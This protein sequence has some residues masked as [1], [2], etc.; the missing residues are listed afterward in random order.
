[1]TKTTAQLQKGDQAPAFDLP[2]S[3][4]NNISLK[5]LKGKYAVIYF[6]PKDNTPGCTIEACGFRDGNKEIEK[7]NAVIVGVSP[8]SVASH[9]RFIEKFNLPFVLVSDEDKQMCQDYGVW[10]KKNKFGRKYMGVDRK[11]FIVGKNGKILKIFEKVKPAE[12]TAEVID[13][14]KSLS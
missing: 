6:Y 11:T 5:P 13:F 10:I 9:N 8:D 1:M 7:L 12:H 4:G 14:L 3:D 2:S